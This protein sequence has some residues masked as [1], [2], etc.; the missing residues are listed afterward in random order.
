M[1][2]IRHSVQTLYQAG[3]H[4]HEQ[5]FAHWWPR[6]G[7]QELGTTCHHMYTRTGV[8]GWERN[9]F[10]YTC[11]FMSL[12]GPVWMFWG[13]SS[14]VSTG[15]PI[16]WRVQPALIRTFVSVILKLSLRRVISGYRHCVRSPPFRGATQCRLVLSYRRFKFSRCDR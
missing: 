11:L 7:V 5:T 3:L 14:K 12:R 8:S 1:E 9:S 10:K 15:L 13:S 2:K 4:V 6:S 16:R